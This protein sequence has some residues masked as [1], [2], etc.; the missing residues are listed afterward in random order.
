[1]EILGGLAMFVVIISGGVWVSERVTREARKHIP[2]RARQRVTQS[3]RNAR[4]SV[5][6]IRA[7]PWA[8]ARSANWLEK[9]RAARERKAAAPTRPPRAATAVRST[10]RAV[11]SAAGRSLTSARNGSRE[12]GRHALSVIRP[13]TTEYVPGITN[14]PGKS[15]G[16]LA[17]AAPAPE[18]PASS[19]PAAAGSSTPL[20]V[21][22]NTER[23][24]M[25]TIS[26]NTIPPDF[27]ALVARIAQ[28]EPETDADLIAFL[29]G[30]ATGT[31]AIGDALEQHADHLS[32]G[33]GLD[34]A[35][36]AAVTEAAQAFTEAAQAVSRADARFQALYQGVRETAASGTV[37]PFRG[38]FI[39]GESA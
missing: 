11:R 31:A 3:A 36:T 1:M 34:P 26:R 32:S 12:A 20:L 10:G 14:Q 13:R 22:A 28:F 21:S 35:A 7:K 24:A 27:A 33:V 16:Q 5:R 19:S 25:A 23:P 4:Q 17:A 6:A 18:P 30:I 38:R 9:K 29:R 8:E 37:L 2:D 39:T 15:A